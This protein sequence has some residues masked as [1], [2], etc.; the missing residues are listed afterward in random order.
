[1]VATDATVLVGGRSAIAG[2]DRASG[3]ER[4]VVDTED[5]VFGLVVAENTVFTFDRGGSVRGWAV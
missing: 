4:W 1:V 5:D 2:L 3:S